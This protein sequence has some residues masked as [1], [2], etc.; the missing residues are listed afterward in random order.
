MEVI[1]HLQALGFSQYEAQAYV[2]LLQK[3]PLNGYE[4]AKASRIPRPNIYAVLQKLEESGA[5]MRITIPDGTRYVPVPVDELLMKLERRYQRSL[6]AATVSLQQIVSIPGAESILSFR[7]Y[8]ELLEQAWTLLDQTKQHLL[9]SIWPEE[10]TALAEPVRQALDRGVQ[11]TTLCLRGCPQPCPACQGD[12]FRY[13]IAPENGTRWLVIVSDENELLAGEI[14][15]TGSL[16]STTTVRTCQ[17][18]LVNL[19]GGYIQNS[20]AL[21]SI[22]TQSGSRLMSQLDPQ[23]AAAL[24]NLHPFHTQ[25]AWLGRM[26]HMLHLDDSASQLEKTLSE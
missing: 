20:I 1:Q 15:S 11:I 24:N 7:G 10:A 2:A 6:E 25:G 21:S 22:L 3:N 12:V 26:Q 14:P 8:T 16:E 9:L 19:T 18:M 23:S 13:A 5:V 17:Q 4:L